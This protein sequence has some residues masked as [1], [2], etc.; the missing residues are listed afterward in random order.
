MTQGRPL[1]YAPF[2]GLYATGYGE[3]APCCVSKK[4][5]QDV[6]AEQ[7]WNSEP[8]KKTRQKLLA[9]EFPDD[10]SYC[11]NKVKNELSSDIDLWDKHYNNETIDVMQGNETGAPKYL[12]YR[13]TNECN[14]KCRMCV[15]NASSQIEREFEQHPDMQRWR[16]VYKNEL[17]YVDELHDYLNRINLTQI[18]ILGGEPTIDPTV[19][20]L[21]EK[22]IDTHGND[23]PE[24]RFTTNGTNLNKRFQN[25]MNKFENISV[26]FSVDA[27]GDTYNYIRTNGAWN[28]TQAQIE[29]S[30]E[31]RLRDQPK[32]F[33]VVLMPYNQFAFTDLLDWFHDLYDRGHRFYINFDDSDIGYSSMSAILPSDMRKFIT[34]ITQWIDQASTGFMK[35]IGGM[36]KLLPLLQGVKYS[37]ENYKEFVA[38]NARLDKIR[39]SSLTDLDTRFKNYVINQSMCALPFMHYSIKPNNKIKPCCRFMTWHEDHQQD[40]AGLSVDTHTPLQALNSEAM[41][42]VRD[43]MLRGERIS[44]C[45]KCYKEEET[46]GDSMRTL[47]NNMWNVED[48][49]DG[50]TQLEYLEVAFGNYCNLSCRTCGS[51][52]SS[53]WYEDDIKLKPLYTERERA[54]QR[55]NVE[56]NWKPSDFDTVKEIKF[57]GGEPMLHPNFIKF[58]DAIIEGNN[59]DHILLDIFTNTSW[60]PKDKVLSRLDK[61]KSVKIWLSV[62]GIGTTQKYVRNGSDWERVQASAESWLD[63][64]KLKPE[65]YSIVLTPT[66]NV[67]NVMQ[68]PKQVDWWIKQRQSRDLGFMTN[69]KSGDVVLSMVHDPQY[70]SLKMVP[71]KHE[72]IEYLENCNKYD[73]MTFEHRLLN[74]VIGRIHGL[75]KSYENSTDISEFIR[76]TKDLDHLR[77]QSLKHAIPELYERTNRHLADFNTSFEQIERKLRD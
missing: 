39:K 31:T 24:L 54:P 15:P 2:I 40:F 65:I 34:R 17:K 47:M 7:Y 36:Q 16:K 49:L 64:E 60:V 45:N 57:T 10:C 74:K 43:A 50:S 1:C 44:G 41:Q 3:Y 76:F 38:Y 6:T 75:L 73:P 35:D 20:Q 32:S 62:D 51:G 29:H 25:I 53:S 77:G 59:Q 55:I 26:S 61:F 19:I 8:L 21:L 27:V 9:G 58:L 56:F 22:L 28:K 37:Y 63:R 67:Y 42:G 12:D 70:L 69:H 30:F 48:R 5:K 68:I 11:E 71:C 52:L 33:N 66:C 13:P 72:V 4:H 23:L 14:L 18:K 46:T